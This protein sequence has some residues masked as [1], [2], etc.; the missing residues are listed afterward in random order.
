MFSSMIV[1]CLL[2]LGKIT[3][4]IILK[5]EGGETARPLDR[6]RGPPQVS[7][8]GGAEEAQHR[9]PLHHRRMASPR[10]QQGQA[11]E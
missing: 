1:Q 2:N 4:I 7:V 8:H 9:A 5:G 3:N 11:C 10:G 6:H